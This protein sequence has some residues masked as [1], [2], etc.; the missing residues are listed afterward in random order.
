MFVKENKEENV[1]R[2]L[3]RKKEENIKVRQ[4]KE[5]VKKMR[6]IK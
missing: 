3:F 4:R 2:C 5:E 6:K 1:R